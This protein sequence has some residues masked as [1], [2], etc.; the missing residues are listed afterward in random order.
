M[1]VSKLPFVPKASGQEIISEMHVKFQ[2]VVLFAVCADSANPY[3][4][5]GNRPHDDLTERLGHLHTANQVM[6][7]RHIPHCLIGEIQG[8]VVWTGLP[9]RS[10][11]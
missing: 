6:N 9:A 4:C 10:V 1:E 7:C 2:G 5:F 11:F 3:C 8:N